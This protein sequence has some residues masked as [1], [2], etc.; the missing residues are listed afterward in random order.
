MPLYGSGRD[1]GVAAK[2]PQKR[3]EILQVPDPNNIFFPTERIAFLCVPKAANT[4]L[5]IAICRAWG[6]RQAK[7]PGMNHWMNQLCFDRGAV[8]IASLATL[9]E[10][11]D[12]L[13]IA[14]VR[15][16]FA[17]VASYIR[18]KVWRNHVT[19]ERIGVGADSSIEQIVSAILETDP[20]VCDHHYRAM[21]QLLTVGEYLIPDVVV[22]LEDIDSGW[23]QIRRAVALWCGRDL[24]AFPQANI[25][26]GPEILFSP[27]QAERLTRRYGEDL[28]R[29]GYRAGVG[30]W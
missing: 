4:S 16:P 14:L 5:K 17:R 23:P 10:L 29:F 27:S 11:S 6:L 30:P 21:A 13:R 7:W 8:R 12:C 3:R 22:R 18:D 24:G 19:A 1:R 25:T 26:G 15:H 2:S 9:L 20:Q 28:A